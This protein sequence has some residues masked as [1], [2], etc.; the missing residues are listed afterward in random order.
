MTARDKTAEGG[1]DAPTLTDSDLDGADA[2]ALAETL[3]VLGNRI[4]LDLAEITES[5]EAGEEIST[6]E[7]EQLSREL[8]RTA[9][10]LDRNLLDHQTPEDL[11][12]EQR[13]CEGSTGADTNISE[14]FDPDAL[15]GADPVDLTF[16]LRADLR[17]I[18]QYAQVVEHNIL[19][20][21]LGDYHI[22]QLWQ[23]SDTLAAW[24]QKV[25]CQRVDY[26]SDDTM[27]S[28]RDRLSEEQ[29]RQLGLV[30]SE[31]EETEVE[32]ADPEEVVGGAL[33]YE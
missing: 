24:C 25:L 31:E 20:G 14:T 26:H 29:R 16:H 8:R 19:R 30:G 32:E 12:L 2:H 33:G 28:Q 23:A 11:T 6:E 13:W 18:T 27:I 3:D 22:S 21:S 5:I 10:T 4:G 15:I 1:K 17:K 9:D 7:V